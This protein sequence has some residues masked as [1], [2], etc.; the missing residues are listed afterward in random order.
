MGEP[1][2]EVRFDDGTG[3][4]Q[5]PSAKCLG[6]HIYSSGDVGKELGRRLG[7]AARKWQQLGSFWKSALCPPTWKLIIYDAGIC[8]KLVYG[9]ATV[10]LTQAQMPN[11]DAFQMRGLRHILIIKHTC[12]G[13]ESTNARVLAAANGFR[14]PNGG[15]IQ[16]FSEN[17]EKQRLSLMG[18][19]LRALPEDPMRCVTF[20]P[21]CAAS[22][23]RRNNRV[24][25]LRMNW[26]ID[27]YTQAWQ[28]VVGGRGV[29][30]VGRRDIEEA[31]MRAALDRSF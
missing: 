27:C 29:Y 22:L 17:Y 1:G 31:V 16:R 15:A 10:A 28:T 11:V 26:T 14:F 3:L 4:A 18:H 7:D 21:K 5:P 25:R 9:L 6:C 2:T 12:V 20:V 8:A 30:E 19:V 24:G 13:R 23:F